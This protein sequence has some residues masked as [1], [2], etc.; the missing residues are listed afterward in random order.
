MMFSQ[1]ETGCNEIYFPVKY[2]LKGSKDTVKTKILNI[3]E[4]TNEEFSPAAYL[5][6]I[7]ILDPSGN[8]VKIPENNIRYME[9]TDLN[10]AG[11]IFTDAKPV[12]PRETGLLQI[13]YSGKKTVWYRKSA[14]SGPIYT[15]RI[16]HTEYLLFRKDRKIKELHFNIPGDLAQLKDPFNNHPDLLL[17][18]N[19]VFQDSDLIR[20][21]RL[22]DK[23]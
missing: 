3:G 2:V 7:T 9:I 22:Y 19:T 13:M 8:K 23:K 20:I 5:R 4:Y 16:N 21:L 18:L 12:L 17:M 10:K 1:K 6:Q 15:N 14:Y 11:R